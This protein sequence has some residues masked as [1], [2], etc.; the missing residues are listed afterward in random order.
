MRVGVCACVCERQREIA[1]VERDRV[2]VWVCV[3]KNVCVSERVR[4]KTREIEDKRIAPDNET[5]S[6]QE[7]DRARARHRDTDRKHICI[8][9]KPVAE[10]VLPLLYPRSCQHSSNRC[11]L[12]CCGW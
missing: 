10:Q 8:C 11:P 7:R 3:D 12:S 6:T 1:R 4:A 9:Y 2:C 5:D